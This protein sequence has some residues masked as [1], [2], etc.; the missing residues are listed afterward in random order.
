MHNLIWT[1]KPILAPS[2]ISVCNLCNL[3]RSVAELEAAGIQA[4][5]I[6]IL[7]G[8]FSPSMPMG[9]DTVRQLRKITDL[10]FDVHVMAKENAFFVQELLDIGVAQITFHL[11]TE[12]HPDHMLNLL[13][14]YGV[15]AGIAL[16][17]GTSLSTMDYLLEKCDTVLL[18]LINPGYAQDP[19]ELQ[20]PYAARKIRDL[21]EMIQ[22]NGF[23]TLIEVD[24]RIS[25]ENVS[26]YISAGADIIV[27]GSTCLE[28]G[29]LTASSSKLL[30]LVS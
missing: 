16:K 26:D 4:L 22:S 30:S 23:N 19:R 9:L 15:R 20:V 12:P 8:Y 18:M 29:N 5:H 14:S 21:H 27:A 11:E 10:V 17:P 24:G 13:H 6:D 28:K 3:E 2:L 7:D 1:S 25:S